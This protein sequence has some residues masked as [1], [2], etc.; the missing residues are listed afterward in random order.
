MV[1]P[2]T[3]SIDRLIQVND[4]AMTNIG[5]F[6]AYIERY[7][8]TSSENSSRHDTHRSAIEPRGNRPSAGI[9]RF[10]ERY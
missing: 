10:H 4:R 8:A 2:R 7:L 9:L 1:Q 6:R 5:V 3:E